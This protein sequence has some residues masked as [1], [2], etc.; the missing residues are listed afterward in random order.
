MDKIQLFL[1]LVTVVCFANGAKILGFSPLPIASHN[2]LSKAVLRA[3]AEAGHDV[4]AVTCY[5]EDKHPKGGKWREILLS[6][7]NEKFS[8]HFTQMTGRDRKTSF[9]LLGIQKMTLEMTETPLASPQVQDLI[10]SG[11]KFDV[12][13]VNQFMN[14][15]HYMLAAHFDAHLVVLSTIGSGPMNNYLVRQS[16]LHY[17]LFMQGVKVACNWVFEK[18]YVTNG[19]IISL[20]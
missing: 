13:I 15:A 11:E 12:V 4:T 18:E 6:D 16:K 19:K 10:K 5:H 9:S 3:L 7:Y 2:I 20:E 8:G 17:N 14:E 1:V